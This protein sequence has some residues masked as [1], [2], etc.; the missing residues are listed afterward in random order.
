MQEARGPREWIA[1][2]YYIGK[3]K[4]QH[5]T[6]L[7]ADQ[8]RFVSKIEADDHRI[9][10]HFGRLEPRKVANSA[11]SELGKYLANLKTRID[12]QVFRDLNRIARTHRT[13]ETYVEKAVDVMLAV[14]LVLMAERDEFDAAYLL[15]ADGDYTPAVN[16]VR[17]HGKKVYV[18]SCNR[19]A[20]L[21]ARADSF[22]RLDAAWFSDCY[23]K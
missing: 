17:E 4:Q 22:I 5:N 19:G 9:R 7:Y 2:R 23:R 1:T 13:T 18:A 11:A 21:A 20:Q 3:V 12:P 15:T 6:Q 16:A 8:R 14:D 10:V